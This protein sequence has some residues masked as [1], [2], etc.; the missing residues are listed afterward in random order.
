[1]NIDKFD[2]FH[3]ALLGLAVGDAVGTTLE[4]TT[5]GTFE[6]ITNM[7]GGGPFSLQAG[8]WTDDTSMALC[9]ATSLVETGQFD[10]SDQMERYV[11]WWRDG[12]LSSTGT[13]FDIGNTV[14]HA[15]ATFERN[16]YPYAGSKDKMS[17]GNGSLMRL[18]PVVMA[19]A[20]DVK[21][22]VFYAGKSSCTTHSTSVCIDACRYFAAL[23]LGALLGESKEKI[24]DPHHAP[25]PNFD[26]SD[27]LILD[28]YHIAHGSYKIKQPPDIKGSGYVV[29]S[30]EA[31]LWAFYNSDNFRDGCLL[32]ANLGDDA[33]TT[34][35]IYGQLAG[36]YYGAS[37]IPQAWRSTVAMADLIEALSKE[38]M[39]FVI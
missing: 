4:F 32:A 18:A 11:R 1:M 39:N 28:I 27:T 7:V 38:L 26:Y 22:G 33:D 6:P 8:Q 15:L 14:R 36:A 20:G 24:L 23:L 9:L 35:A 19:F 34:A 5:P 25:I 10:P 16:G 12:Y 17:A 21:K 2:H 13:C 3:G 30:L 37:G 31:A 29:Q